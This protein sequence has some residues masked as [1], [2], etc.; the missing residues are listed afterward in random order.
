MIPTKREQAPPVSPGRI[1]ITRQRLATLFADF[2]PFGSPVKPVAQAPS[3]YVPDPRPVDIK[4]PLL[5][6]IDSNA[7]RTS[8]L[9]EK[10]VLW[11]ADRAGFVD[12]PDELYV[13][14][15]AFVG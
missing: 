13:Q 7:S 14:I 10:T 1:E 5:S 3:T 9:G 15:C 6:R 2:S 8:Q 12:L 11:S 4:H